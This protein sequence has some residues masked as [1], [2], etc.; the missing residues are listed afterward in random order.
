MQAHDLEL[1]I[2][3]ARGAGHIATKFTGPEAKAWDKPGGAGPVTE[4]DLAVNA[5]LLDHLRSARPDYGW[6]SEESEDSADRL[7]HD[8]VFIVDPID[9]T[10]SFIEGNRTWAH[11]IAIAHKG[12]I[13]AGVVFL[14]MRDMMY[15]AAKGQGATLNDAP[16]VA[17]TQNKLSQATLL[18]AK[19]NFNEKFWA[20]GNVPAFKMAYRPSLAYRMALVAQGRHDGMITFRPTWEWDIAAGVLI[21]EES[22]ARTSDRTGNTLIF[23]AKDPRT[24]GII[25]A[26]PQL[27]TDLVTRHVASA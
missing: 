26:A 14:P 3:A 25:A 24:H 20:K 15:A 6:L 5:F 17:S 13:T 23:N 21:A 27:H 12:V 4:A 10:R 8:T 16:L 7:H 19:P 22:G 2:D 11:S 1:L 9:G 18:S